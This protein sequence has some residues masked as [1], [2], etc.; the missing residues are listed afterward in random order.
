MHQGMNLLD[1]LRVARSLGVRVE[2]VRRTGEIRLVFPDAGKSVKCNV[3]RKAATRCT[4]NFL[5]RVAAMQAVAD[6]RHVL[7]G[8]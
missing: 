8:A 3:S 1:A 4:V 2:N 5:K 7:E 6:Q